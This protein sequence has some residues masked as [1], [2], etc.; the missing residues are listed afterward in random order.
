MLQTNNYVIFQYLPYDDENKL[1]YN[2]ILRQ[3]YY[4]PEKPY[5]VISNVTSSIMMLQ[6]PSSMHFET[7]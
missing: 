1:C 5:I 3:T 6:V 7:G 2:K 4:D